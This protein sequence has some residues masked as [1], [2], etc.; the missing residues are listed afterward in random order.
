MKSNPKN[1]KNIRLIRGSKS[2]S[3]LAAFVAVGA[4]LAGCASNASAPASNPE[5]QASAQTDASPK[6]ADT[7]TVTIAD[8]AAENQTEYLKPEYYEG[9]LIQPEQ[10]ALFNELFRAQQAGDAEAYASLFTQ[11]ASEADK[12]ISF[13]V[14]KVEWLNL[15]GQDQEKSGM[16]PIGGVV[17]DQESG[18]QRSILYVLK[19]ENGDWKI[20]SIQQA[21]E[22]SQIDESGYA[23]D[24]LKIAKLINASVAYQNEQDAEG[25]ASLYPPDSEAGKLAADAPK[26]GHIQVFD[27][28]DAASDTIIANVAYKIE[29]DS[30]VQVNAYIFTYQDGKWFLY[31]ID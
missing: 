9:S 4:L 25:Y 16:Y 13:K 20:D 2:R 12:T 1:E 24:A 21:S 8:Q 6:A 11:E 27:I 5:P 31:G 3:L 19:Q 29:G 23:G 30:K 28:P 22:S 14:D 7:T 26:I 17:Q 10:I 15:Y 18:Q